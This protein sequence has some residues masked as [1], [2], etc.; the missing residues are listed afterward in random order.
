MI[1]DAAH[2][3]PAF[4]LLAF[5]A[6][7]T[8]PLAAAVFFAGALFLWLNPDPL[9]E[10]FLL[11]YSLA[12]RLNSP[13][14]VSVPLFVLAGELAA[15]S[16]IADRLLEIADALIGRPPRSAGAR[17]IL[18]CALFATVSG[19]GPAAAGAAGRRFI[20]GLLA[21]GRRPEAAAGLVAA[22]AAL[23]IVIPTSMP[24]TLYA[25][26]TGMVTNI[27]F[28]AT[29]IP[30]LLLAALLLAA[31]ALSR[32]PGNAGA[33]APIAAPGRRLLSAI[34]DG[35]WAI[36]L[37]VLVLSALFSG[38][39]TAPEAAA[40]ASA[41]A[42]AAGRLAFG[43][44]RGGELWDVLGRAAVTAS[45]ALLLV[46]M[47]G[48]F[49]MVLEACGF[50]QWL[51]GAMFEYAGGRA[52]SIFLMILILLGAG[53]VLDV[54]AVIALVAPPLLPLA[55]RS[56]MSTAHFG[57]MV[58]VSLAIGL[59]TPPQAS[60]LEVASELAGVGLRASARASAP[61]LLAM[62]LCLLAVAY[63]PELSLWLPRRFGWPV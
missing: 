26:A 9:P 42:A 2:L 60:N 40:F 63:V 13:A 31:L 51:A 27:V 38:F 37:P 43:R 36:L 50:T 4:A 19:V 10:G 24:Q 55:E 18:G 21:A 15:E 6:V 49:L 8:V 62:L 44:L 25:A 35:K 16:G 57:V 5:L 48:L 20:P 29:F 41:Y 56:G 52:G 3:L 61:F 33:A 11:Q 53:C 47:G 17:T 34:R 7:L 59:V 46:G 14:L 54:P 22:S 39:F 23:A 12:M 30:G 45:G 58:V 28:T 32:P 1:L